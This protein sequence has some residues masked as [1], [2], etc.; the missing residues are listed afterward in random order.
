MRPTAAPRMNRAR[1]AIAALGPY[2]RLM[3]LH[4]PIGALLLLWPTLWALWLAGD[5]RPDAALVA[6]FIAGVCVMRAAGCVINDFADRGI[7]AHVWRT[8]DRPLARGEVPPRR[9]LL[10]FALLLLPA[11]A[12]AL[13]LN[14][15]AQLLAPAAVVIA[16][17][18]PFTKRITRLPQLALGIAFSW[19]IPM[20]YAAQQAA[21]PAEMWWLFAANFVWVVAYD[22]QYAMADREDDLRIGVKSSAILF[23]RHDRRII[24]LLHLACLALLAAIGWQRA[25]HWHFYAALALALGCAAYQLHLCKTRERERCLRA[26]LNNNWFGAAI[27]CGLA[28][29]LRG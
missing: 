14:R 10:L 29:A 15:E 28:L 23:G 19:G 12:L 13:Q 8:R 11:L 7:D 2:L 18:Y 20:A 24:A 21:L 6:I 27:F 16:A 25:L 17:L 1:N 22:T 4:R 3:R 26:F 5:G 9:A